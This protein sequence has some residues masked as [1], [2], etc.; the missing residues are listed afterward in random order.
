MKQHKKALFVWLA[1]VVVLLLGA[2]AVGGH[3]R[4]ESIREAMRDAVLHDVNQIDLFGVKAVNPGL[5]S[6]F[7]VTG[8][9]LFAAALL[10]I[11]VIPRF[12]LRP[13]KLQLL[14]E[15]AVGL[16]D[17]MAKGAS[18]HRCGFLGAYIWKI[19]KTD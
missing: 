13:G 19:G 2:L 9:L 6:A 1:A 5:I 14:L 15:Q 12:K 16:F 3:P 10:R 7:V 4:A 18:P 8:A 11:F 17:N